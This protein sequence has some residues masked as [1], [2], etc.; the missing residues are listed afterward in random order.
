MQ[1]RFQ[2]M[3]GTAANL[4]HCP[5]CG[6]KRMSP[7][8]DVT[9]GREVEGFG[10]C[11]REM[12]CGFMQIPQNDRTTLVDVMPAP[13]R[14][15]AQRMFLD[16]GY[17]DDCD[18]PGLFREYLTRNFGTDGLRTTFERFGL[19]T[20]REQGREW[21][22]HWHIERPCNIHTAKLMEY[23]LRTNAMG[24]EVL[25]R[26]KRE[27]AINWAHRKFGPFHHQGDR[28]TFG[29]GVGE[30]PW[31]QTLYGLQQLDYM[32]RE[33][34]CIVEGYKAA[35][36][37]ALYMP[38]YVWLAADSVSSLTAYDKQRLPMMEPLRGRTVYLLP[39]FDALG[40][41]NHAATIC[42]NA[43]HDVQVHPHMEQMTAIASK[44]GAGCRDIEDLL[45]NF[46]TEQWKHK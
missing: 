2:L 30:E 41:W 42:K 22:V 17:F 45:L 20:Y 18:R 43:G 27:G 24:R 35:I 4:R 15:R 13:K 46:N 9:T 16:F 5:R 8:L 25:K 19:G 39:D 23:E 12:S 1:Y 14:E 29:E 33:P 31:T 11:N 21:A 26:V 3:P 10:R 7:Y 32:K 38:R 40:K 37:A 34:V 36:I 6:Q 44:L 28:V